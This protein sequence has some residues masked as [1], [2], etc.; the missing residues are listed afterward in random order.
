MTV[1]S[2]PDGLRPMCVCAQLH[3]QCAAHTC[4]CIRGDG[5]DA[6]I[7]QLLLAAIEPAQLTIALEAIEPLEAQARAID[8]QWHLRIE[9]ARYEA[10]R[11]RRRSEAVEPAFR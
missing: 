3:T 7:A 10:E 6:A 11:A 9:R 1:R 4:Q 8:H 2:M 5:M